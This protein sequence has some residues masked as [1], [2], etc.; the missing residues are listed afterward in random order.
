MI[1]KPKLDLKV[2]KITCRI[3]FQCINEIKIKLSYATMLRDTEE[4]RR[5]RRELRR[6]FDEHEAVLRLQGVRG[7][8]PGGASGLSGVRRWLERSVDLGGLLQRLL[9]VE[10]VL[11]AAAESAGGAGLSCWNSDDAPGVVWRSG[12]GRRRRR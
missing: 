4:L 3:L 10:Q 6:R 7:G 9:E 5:R 12:A 11:E 2:K 1:L 8:P